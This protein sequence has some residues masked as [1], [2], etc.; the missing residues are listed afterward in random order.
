METKEP[1]VVRIDVNATA[2]S[3]FM[4]RREALIADELTRSGIPAV[5]GPTG[6][7]VRVGVLEVTSDGAQTVFTWTPP[8]AVEPIQVPVPVGDNNV[9]VKELQRSSKKGK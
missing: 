4:G 6:I 3:M 5:G 8:A 2:R 7:T 1:V 9:E